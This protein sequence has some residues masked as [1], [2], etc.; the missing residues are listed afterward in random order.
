MTTPTKE[1]KLG[2][3]PAATS[4]RGGWNVLHFEPCDIEA[5]KTKLAARYHLPADSQWQHV[6]SWEEALEVTQREAV[7]VLLLGDFSGSESHIDALQQLTGQAE[8]AV[9]FVLA[10]S[11]SPEATLAAGKCGAKGFLLKHQLTGQGLGDALHAAMRSQ[12]GSGGIVEERRK[13]PRYELTL[14]AVVFPL[15]DN[16]TPR[17]EVVGTTLDISRSGIALLVESD[18]MGVGDCAV[19]GIE[20][21]D[22]VYRYATVEWRVRRL[23]L[24]AIRLGGRFLSRADDPLHPSQLAARFQPE[25]LQYAPAMDASLLSEWTSRGILRPHLVDRVLSCPECESL[26]TFR[27]GCPDCGAALTSRQKLIH[28][29][30]CALVAPVDEFS[31]DPLKCPKCQESNLVV[32]ADFEYLEGPFDCDECN[33]SDSQLAMIAECMG[34]AKR[35]SAAEARSKEVYEYRMPRLDPK[36]LIDSLEN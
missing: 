19:V 9:L 2:E 26:P 21:P 31:H 25:K 11:N 14:P 10:E 13:D 7:D 24:P 20:C 27:Y 6:T 22:G 16:G 32:G 5:M 36:K 8:S 34:C 28:H 29:F 17:S 18:T 35:F 1:L 33:W 3:S 23:K 30:A 4:K 12:P 15:N